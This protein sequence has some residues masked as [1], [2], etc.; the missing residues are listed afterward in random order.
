MG[1]NDKDLER[2]RTLARVLDSAIGVPGTR[3]RFGADALVGLIPGAGDL[4]GAALSGYIILAAARRGAPG[5]VLWRMI[6]NVAIDTAFGAVPVL[7]DLF[8]VAWRSNT[9]NAELL[10]R[11][12]ATPV[13]VT[14]RSRIY[15]MTFAAMLLVVLAGIVALG[16]LIVRALWRLLTG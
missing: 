9:R 11:F 4:L 3:L 14:R 7:G 10:E 15:G 2:V 6:G 16:F 12:V 8:D 5:A 1:S 13:A